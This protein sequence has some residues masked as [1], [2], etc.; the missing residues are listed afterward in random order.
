MFLL[1]QV[2]E[3]LRPGFFRLVAPRGGRG[4]I[5]LKK[6]ENIGV[7]LFYRLGSEHKSSRI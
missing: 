2:D 3:A 1:T 5:A 7:S 4:K 6:G